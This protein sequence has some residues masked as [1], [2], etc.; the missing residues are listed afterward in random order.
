M[1]IRFLAT[2]TASAVPNYWINSVHS[3]C[4][5]QI[6]IGT[7]TISMVR[8]SVRPTDT[9]LATDMENQKKGYETRK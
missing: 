2:A 6:D 9:N 5:M 8:K 4:T 1:L 3:D 7:F